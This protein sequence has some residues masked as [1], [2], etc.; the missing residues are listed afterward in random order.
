MSFSTIT[1]LKTLIEKGKRTK[2]VEACEDVVAEEIEKYVK[3]DSFYE[4]PTNEI[5]KIVIKSEIDDIDVLCELIS[6]MR[7]KKRGESTLLLNV[8]KREEA[9][10]EECIKILSTFKQCPICKH[11]NELFKNDKEFPDMDYEY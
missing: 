5:L 9:T 1:E 2:K 11:M 8:I 3:E 4:L 6:R 10:L 7:S